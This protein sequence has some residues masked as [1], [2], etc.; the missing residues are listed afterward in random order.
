MKV[1]TEQEDVRFVSSP[2]HKHDFDWKRWCGNGTFHVRWV[3]PGNRT[4]P[5]PTARVS[6]LSCGI[7]AAVHVVSCVVWVEQFRSLCLQVEER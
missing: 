3:G 4:D 6:Q 7:C 1:R 2:N 5:V